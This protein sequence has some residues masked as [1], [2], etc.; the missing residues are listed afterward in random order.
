MAALHTGLPVARY[1][2]IAM[3]VGGGLAGL[4]GMTQVAGIQFRLNPESAPTSATRVS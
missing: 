4:A 1:T 3:I 2:I